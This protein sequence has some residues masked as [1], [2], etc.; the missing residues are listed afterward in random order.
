MNHVIYID[1]EFTDLLKPEL[2][3]LGMVTFDGEQHYVELDLADPASNSTVKN[4]S[5]FVRHCGVLQQWGRVPKSA[6]S[7]AQMGQRTARWLL[8]QAERFG[9]PALI[10]FDYSADYELLESLLRYADQWEVVREVVRPSNVAEL[11]WRF[12]G[13]L[14]AEA[15]YEQLRKRGLERHNALADAHAL[16]AACIAATTGKRVTL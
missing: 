7:Y 6:A 15:A 8:A 2:L 1:T 3:S 14:G 5:D 9:Q 16:R 11:A 4:A 13:M 10:A 12:D